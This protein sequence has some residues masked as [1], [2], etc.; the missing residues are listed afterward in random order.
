MP[1]NKLY[2]KSM[3]KAAWSGMTKKADDKK[4]G[5]IT[6]RRLAKKPS[7][8]SYSK[9]K[10]PKKDKYKAPKLQLKR[11]P[12][13]DVPSQPDFDKS[14][15]SEYRQLEGRSPKKKMVKKSTTSYRRAQAEKATNE[16]AKM[17]LERLRLRRAK[18]NKKKIEKMFEGM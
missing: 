16:E 18:S 9:K 5:S 7:D 4:E 1:K 10:K 11:V 8:A 12:K 13:K 2:M 14:S 3:G 6:I 17:L 15:K